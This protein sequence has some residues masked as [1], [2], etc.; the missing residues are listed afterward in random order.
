MEPNILFPGNTTKSITTIAK[1]TTPSMININ[2]SA[3]IQPTLLHYKVHLLCV[4]HVSPYDGQSS[5]SIFT[6]TE[7]SYIWVAKNPHLHVEPVSPYEGQTS[8]SSFHNYYIMLP[9]CSA[10]HPGYPKYQ[11][12]MSTL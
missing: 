1:N 2:I 5:C 12:A 9:G 11:M 8:H 4:A 7:T 10:L 3:L 6:V